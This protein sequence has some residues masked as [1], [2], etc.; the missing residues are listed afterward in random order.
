MMLLRA[1]VE[2]FWRVQNYAFWFTTW[3]V[4][5]EESFEKIYTSLI[6]ISNLTLSVA[7][8]T[9]QADSNEQ[10][11][12]NDPEFHTSIIGCEYE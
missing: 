10:Q 11:R 8:G 6:A 1:F 2:T 9:G 4:E 5:V 7:T 3:R 12:V